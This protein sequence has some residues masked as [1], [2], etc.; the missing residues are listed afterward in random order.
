MAK[1]VTIAI[2]HPHFICATDTGI[3]TTFNIGSARSNAKRLKGW[4]LSAGATSATSVT[5]DG[6]VYPTLDA[7]LADLGDIR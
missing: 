6:D 4:L 5:M 7:F 2:A 3:T 1:H